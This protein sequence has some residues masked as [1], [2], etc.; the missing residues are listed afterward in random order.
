MTLTRTTKFAAALVAIVTLGLGSMAAAQPGRRGPDGPGFGRGFGG[1]FPMLR[2]LDLTDAQREQVKA[3]LD[4]NKEEARAT[5]ERI[6]AARKAHHDAIETVPSD[7][8]LIRST[9]N[10]LAGVEADAA[11][12]RSKVYNQIYQ[13]LT[14]EQQEKL[15]TLKAE[16]EKRAA[17]M[18]QRWQERQ[19]QRQQ[20]AT[21]PAGGQV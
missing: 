1:P 6:A 15:K 17:E 2:A 21:P 13:I 5:G 4:Q 20:Q 10:A 19:Q 3:V 8:G 9:A 14:P 7:E 12:Q 16:H 11:V 18:R